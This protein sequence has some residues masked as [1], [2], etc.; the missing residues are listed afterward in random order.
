MAKYVGK[1]FRV[2]NPKL[3]IRGNE[4][5]F[6]HVVWY[7][8]RNKLFK[9]RVITSLEDAYPKTSVDRRI[10]NKSCRTYN[11]ENETHCV[12]NARKYRWLRRGKVEAI[13]TEQTENFGVWSGYS[14]TVYLNKDDLINPTK[15]K[16]RKE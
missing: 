5:H 9:C 7:N 4:T 3:K 1:I 12:L 8:P 15:L 16:I 6:V 10:L 13:P 2:A 11:K 14:K